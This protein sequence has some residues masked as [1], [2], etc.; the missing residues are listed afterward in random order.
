MASS[1][2]ATE[3]GTSIGHIRLVE[4]LGSGGMGEVY[5]GF[6]T[7]L[8]R[9]VAVKTLRAEHRPDSGVRAR[10]LREA[11][12]LSQIDHPAI[13]KVYDLI[14]GEQTN[15]LVFELVD[16]VTLRD[17]LK[18]KD[19][20]RQETLV[21]AEKIA[22][23]LAAAHDERIV[24]RDLKPENVMV[25]PDGEIKI[26]D[27]GI[28]TVLQEQA[29]MQEL[30][31][32]ASSKT[33][34]D[35]PET[36]LN[37]AVLDKEALE[38]VDLLTNA[39]VPLDTTAP[40]FISETAN[41][42]TAN[43]ETGDPGT[44]SDLPTRAEVQSDSLLDGPTT[45]TRKGSVMGTL[46]YM[47]PEQARGDSVT[48]ACDL[49]SFG[50]MLQELLTGRRAYERKQAD[51]LLAQVANAE[52]RPMED[53][54]PALVGLIVE[55]KRRNPELRPT[56]K[57][58][59]KRI[60]HILDGPK[61]FR[62]RRLQWIGVVVSFLFLLTILA[63]VF[64]LY[65]KATREAERANQAVIM[66]EDERDRAKAISDFLTSMFEGA[67][68]DQTLSPDTSALELLQYSADALDS[69][70]SGQ[71][72]RLAGMQSVLGSILRRFGDYP[73]AERLLES[74]LALRKEHLPEGDLEIAQ[75]LHSLGVVLREMGELDQARLLLEEARDLVEPDQNPGLLSTIYLQLGIIQRRLGHPQHAETSVRRALAL[76]QQASGD[77]SD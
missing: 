76:R 64:T 18:A 68:P 44:A 66:A 42:E 60:R 12:L 28:S 16:G 34:L 3:V 62:R 58:T 21:L 59:A 8:E 22:R 23:A 32:E 1:T 17:R 9:H 48:A 55:L 41:S 69:K 75:D 25:T 57:Q 14:E 15:Y 46:H 29:T 24:H 30:Q 45:L 53:E 4:L 36:V 33:F 67:D 52:T 39:S 50:V 11:R 65:Q 63:V 31:E 77:D 51:Q 73:R 43:S 6:D 37:G 7:R 19:L 10:F 13:C 70:L 5:Q 20:N 72:L 40:I 2:T 56:A 26:L 47:S 38:T 71:P 54:N 27:F 35:E 49:Y 74:S 61:R